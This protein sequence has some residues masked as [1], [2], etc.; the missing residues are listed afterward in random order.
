MLEPAYPLLDES[1]IELD[2]W[3][4]KSAVFEDG[5]VI[6]F[7]AVVE[8]L[9]VVALEL[10]LPVWLVWMDCR[11][12]CEADKLD[13]TDCCVLSVCEVGCGVVAVSSLTA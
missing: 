11:D 13:G 1:P 9:L 7:V 5:F 12:A 10:E 2:D 8:T 6:V 3:L 4:I